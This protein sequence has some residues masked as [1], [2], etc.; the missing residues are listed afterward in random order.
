[1]PSLVTVFYLHKHSNVY[2]ALL[3]SFRQA[4]F[5]DPLG[6][7]TSLVL[8]SIMSVY[9]P[10]FMR[11]WCVSIR[12]QASAVSLRYQH[13]LQASFPSLLSSFVQ[14]VKCD[15]QSLV[16]F[17]TQVFKCTSRALFMSFWQKSFCFPLQECT[18]FKFSDFVIR[19]WAFQCKP[20]L[21]AF[22]TLQASFLSLRLSFVQ[23]ANV[24]CMICKA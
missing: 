16:C 1:M 18:S 6:E 15:M 23:V 8:W 5:C 20:R 9:K 11:F 12:V 22:I 24:L 19:M 2:P 4:S 10:R 3:M 7:C 17:F 14:V 21:W 13:Y